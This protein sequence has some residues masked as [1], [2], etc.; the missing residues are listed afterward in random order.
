[1]F[2]LSITHYSR[3]ID[4]LF[5]HNKRTINA[6]FRADTAHNKELI[7]KNI[8]YTKNRKNKQF[9]TKIL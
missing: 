9:Y 4:A 1:M 6:L 2:S 5:T 7:E 8:H 3:T